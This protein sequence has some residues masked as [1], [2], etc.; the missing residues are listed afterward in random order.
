MTLFLELAWKI[1]RYGPDVQRDFLRDFYRQQF[2]RKHGDD[3]ADLKREYFRLC[4][5]R[6]PE[7]LGWNTVYPT[8][9]VRDTSDWT[10]DQATR[11]VA[12]WRV[13]AE[14]ADDMANRLPTEQRPAYFE[15]VQYPAAAGAAM[16]EKMLAPDRDRAVVAYDH[17]QQL[18]RST[19]T[20]S[21]ENGGT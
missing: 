9:P 4:A 14:R 11:F 7:T 21:T 1:D 8:K 10:P 5:I 19:T 12:N 20:S 6:K 17:I 13:L 16:A 15:L 18:T 3:I 2:G